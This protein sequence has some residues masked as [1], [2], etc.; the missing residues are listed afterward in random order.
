[1]TVKVISGDDP[2]TVSALALQAGLGPDL[3]SV[4]GPALDGMDDEELAAVALET[5]VFGRITPAQKER[6]VD[7]LRSR[8]RYVAMIGDGVN[9]VLSLKKANLGIAMQ[10]GSQ[11]ARG[12]ADIVLTND[13]FA[14]LAPAV[15]E[16]Q[17]IRNGMQDILRLFLSRIATLALLIVTSLVIG[18]FPI[19]LRN[20][21]VLTLFTVGIPTVLL[22]LWAQPG[23]RD[24]Q[25][26]ARTLARFVVPAAVRSSRGG[27][28]VLFGVIVLQLGGLGAIAGRGSV[29][30]ATLDAAVSIAQS[31]LTSFLVL[32]GL[33]LVVFVEPPVGWLAVIEPVSRDRRPTILA[34]ALA[35]LYL[36]LLATPAGRAVFSLR[37]LGPAELAIVL[38]AV[39]AWAAAL[40]AVWRYRVV[41][42]FLGI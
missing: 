6:L 28:A 13:S 12:V 16:G 31:S 14:S 33:V 35:A 1:V 22:A 39:A 29:A 21:S 17:R 18:I 34:A 40:H 2:E 8:G 15:E 19:E 23:V 42:R 10:G 25:S 27:L 3:K 20:G 11:A 36:L 30:P 41:E 37:P 32:A 5:A 9:D 38:I 26:L 4:A 24:Q 7:A